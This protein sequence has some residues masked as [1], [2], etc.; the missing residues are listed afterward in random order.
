M[1]SFP[2]STCRVCGSTNTDALPF[3]RYMPF[4]ALRVD[5]A[6]DP[7]LLFATDTFVSTGEWTLFERGVRKLRRIL[8]LAKPKPPRPFR[9]YMTGCKDCHTITPSLEFSYED[10]SGIYRDY[11][12]DAYNRDRISVEPGYAQLVEAVG[13]HP[14][15]ITTRNS[16]VDAFLR[17]NAKHFVRGKMVDY[18]GSDGRFLTDFMFETFDAIEIF[19][20]S[21]APLHESVKDKHVSRTG[22]P[23][24]AGYT[25]L[26]CMHV[27][28]HVGNPRALVLDALRYV[29]PGGLVYLEIPHEL[30]P[31]I[32]SDFSRRIVDGCIGIHEHMNFFDKEGIPRLARSIPGLDLLDSWEQDVD[33]GWTRGTIGRFLIRKA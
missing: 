19:D 15:E 20:V 10:L 31:Q 32:F 25:F 18:G 13:G 16:A 28:E 22:A 11:R 21:N 3:G 27:L 4:F 17:R 23:Q 8:G 33:I 12:S 9:T 26:S 6:K 5:T 30:S 24:E 14:L 29:A 7:Y 2:D 1:G